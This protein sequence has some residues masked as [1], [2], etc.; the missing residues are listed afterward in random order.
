MKNFWGVLT[1]NVKATA[2]ELASTIVEME[3]KVSEAQAGVEKA[4]ADALELHKMKLAGERVQ[5]QDIEAAERKV[6]TA[7]RN[8]KAAEVTLVELQGRLKLAA[9]VKIENDRA[10]VRKALADFREKKKTATRE[11]IIAFAALKALSVGLLGPGAENSPLSCFPEDG[12]EKELFQD[13]LIKQKAQLPKPTLHEEGRRVDY[14]FT[15]CRDKKVEDL[16][17]ELLVSAHKDYKQNK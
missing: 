17:T 5:D 2:E 12:E 14:E 4:E 16:I 6:S 13:A 7:Q 9:E 15:I 8:L 3:Y 1:G 11:Y 10:S